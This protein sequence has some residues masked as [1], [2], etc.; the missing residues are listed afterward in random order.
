M[1]P[2]GLT[3]QYSLCGNR[4]DAHTYR[5]AVLHE[6]NSRGGSAYIYDS[7]TVGDQVGIGG[8]RNNFPMVPSERYLFVAGGIGITPMLPM[9]H[10]ADLIGADWQLLYGGRTRATM[11]FRDD[12]VRHGDRVTVRP[13]DEYG[14]LDLTI[15]TTAADN[16]AKVYACGPTPLLDALA[17]LGACWSRGTLRTERFVARD[18]GAPVRHAPFVV[19]LARTNRT[20]T[21]TPDISVLDAVQS[22]G[23]AVLSSCREGTCGTCETTVLAG[24]PDHRDSVL[25]DTERKAGDC[26]ILC[27]SRSRTDHLVL[28]L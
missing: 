18:P 23:A 12:L 9:I 5:I 10:Q 7:L 17:D 1:L 21:V 19:E 22:A 15:A 26:M 14:R 4:W 24:E 20:V 13:Q 25:D 16:G 8:P 27:V 3:R 2:N 6:P 28:D 11:A